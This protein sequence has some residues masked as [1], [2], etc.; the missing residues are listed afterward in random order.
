MADRFYSD[1]EISDVAGEIVP[2]AATGFVR[3]YGRNGRLF[4]VGVSGTEYD[5][6]ENGGS[7]DKNVDGGF[8]NAIY[9]PTQNI[10]GGDA[11]G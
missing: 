10:D 11:N 7:G 5:L 1:I 4:S 9:L 2:P 6:S 8:A 3:I